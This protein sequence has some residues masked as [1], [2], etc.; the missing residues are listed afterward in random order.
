MKIASKKHKTLKQHW[1]KY[2]TLHHAGWH[3]NQKLSKGKGTGV[4]EQE[5]VFSSRSS[6]TGEHRTT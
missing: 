4:R 3:Y 2:T 1:G 6:F 5:S